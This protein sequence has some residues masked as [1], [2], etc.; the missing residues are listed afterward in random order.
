MSDSLDTLMALMGQKLKKN[1]K[2]KHIL[3][4]QALIIIQNKS[5]KY[6]K[7]DKEIADFLKMKQYEIF[8]IFNNT[9][10]E[11]GKILKEAKEK[12]S[13]TNQHDGLFYK[14][15]TSMGFK[16]DKVYSLI[17]RYKLLVENSD[18]QLIIENLP[19]SLSYEISKKSCPTHLKMKVLNGKIKS[20]KEFKLLLYK[21]D[22]NYEKNSEIK[23]NKTQFTREDIIKIIELL[24]QELKNIKNIKLDKIE[25]K[26][27]LFTNLK[28]MQQKINQ[29][30]KIT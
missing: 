18:K 13:G 6:E 16:K 28:E 30:K 9:Y 17:S 4:K 19:L 21:K 22:E 5:F 3:A 26:K 12:L 10:T 7:L 25:N 1:E 2:D 15:F 27:E 29:M 8:N 14:W 11:I 24:L 23:F 20:L